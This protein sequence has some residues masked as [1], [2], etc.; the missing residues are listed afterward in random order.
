LAYHRT[1]ELLISPPAIEPVSITEAQLHLRLDGQFDADYIQAL[2]VSARHTIEKWCWRALITQTWQY[3]WDRFWWKA[4]IPRGPV[5]VGYNA[6]GIASASWSGNVATI[7]LADG[8]SADQFLATLYVGQSVQISGVSIGG[9]NGT[10]TITALTANG[11]TY[12]LN[13]NLAGAT[14][15]TAATGNNGGVQWLK[16]IPPQGV[17]NGPSSYTTVPTSIWETSQENEIPFLRVAYLQVYPVTRGYRDDVTAQVVC[18]YGSLAEDVPM[19]LRQAIKL[20]LTHMYYNRG[21][22]PAEIPSAIGHLIDPY[23]LKEF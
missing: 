11:F 14:G 18:G 1:N 12:A 4:F 10:F 6:G 16:Y 15:G 13:T 7:V 5:R 17:S 20:L 22:A 2:I 19:P 23:R 9:Y 3:W 21:E 8:T